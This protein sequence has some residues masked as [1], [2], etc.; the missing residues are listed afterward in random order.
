MY[1]FNEK[2]GHIGITAYDIFGDEM[3]P[4]LDPHDGYQPLR[5]KINQIIS[6]YPDLPI[7]FTEPGAW[8]YNRTDSVVY[9]MNEYN[10]MKEQWKIIIEE[11]QYHSVGFTLFTYN[12]YKTTHLGSDGDGIAGFG[13]VPYNYSPEYLE[14]M[15]PFAAILPALEVLGRYF[16]T[17]EYEQFAYPE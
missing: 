5:Y 6:R 11:Q 14:A 2:N 4:N 10:M 15:E 17:L 7:L 12:E 16:D 1:G 3:N 9:Q 8:Q 13:V